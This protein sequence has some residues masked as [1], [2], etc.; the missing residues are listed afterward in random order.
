MSELNTSLKPFIDLI[1]FTNSQNAVASYSI[2]A[3]HGRFDVLD[4]QNITTVSKKI[5]TDYLRKSLGYRGITVSDAMWMGEYGHLTTDKLVVIYLKSLLAGMD[6]QMI[7]G[8]TF[9]PTV[10]FFCDIYDDTLSNNDKTSLTL[11]LGLEWNELRQKFIE[12]LTESTERIENVKRT[13]VHA[14]KIQSVERFIDPKDSTTE[15]RN[16]YYLGLDKLGLQ[17]HE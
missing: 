13:L 6:L 17:I 16:E 4:N 8:K 10:K 5:L 12:R 11:E 3:S 1:Q 7:S 9:A 14:H 2:L 15:L